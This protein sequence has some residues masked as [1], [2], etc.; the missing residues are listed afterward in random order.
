MRQMCETACNTD[1]VSDP[2][3]VML[4]CRLDCR[5]QEKDLNFTCLHHTRL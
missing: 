5:L 2:I 3:L 1:E 4:G